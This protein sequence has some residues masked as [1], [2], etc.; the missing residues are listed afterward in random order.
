MQDTQVQSLGRE[1]PLEEV[2][3]IPSSILAWKMP[4]TE[5]PVDSPQGHEELDRAD[6]THVKNTDF[7]KQCKS[8]PQQVESTFHGKQN[9][10]Y[11]QF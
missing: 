3:A 8:R 5:E 9:R 10:L 2:M 6:H 7:S 11:I 1:G 4:W